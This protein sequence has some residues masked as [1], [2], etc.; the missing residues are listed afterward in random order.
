MSEI[1]Q[2]QRRG[3]P[4]ALAANHALIR[5]ADGNMREMLTQYKETTSELLE[6]AGRAAGG[7]RGGERRGAAR[8][9]TASQGT[10]SPGT[11]SRETPLPAAA[12]GSSLPTAPRERNINAASGLSRA[13][14]T[15]A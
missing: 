12:R 3:G 7:G 14:H 2:N 10:V 4:E 11:A 13:G 5:E 8:G 6:L 1:S 9:G 15:R